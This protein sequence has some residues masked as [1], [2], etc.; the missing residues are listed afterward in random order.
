MKKIGFGEI[1]EM[2]NGFIGG[3][4]EF[5]NKVEVVVGVS[6]G[7]L[8]PAA[9]LAAKIDKPLIAA[10]INKQDEIFFDRGDWISDKNILVVDDIIRSGKTL[11]LLKNC[12]QKNCRLKSISFFAL[13]KVKSLNDRKYD[14][15]SFFQEIDSDIIFPW[16]CDR[17]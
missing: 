16:D 2:I 17:K 15:S 9:L 6:R 5:L 7:G 12:L 11:R 14:I 3:N 8:V 1:E 13:F 4:K 10:Y